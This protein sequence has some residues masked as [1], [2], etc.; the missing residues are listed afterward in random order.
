VCNIAFRIAKQAGLRMALAA[1]VPQNSSIIRLSPTL[2]VLPP[3]ILTMT[4]AG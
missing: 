1:D 3:V 2:A 4:H